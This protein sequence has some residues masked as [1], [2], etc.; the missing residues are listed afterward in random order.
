MNETR[1]S[2]ARIPLRWMIRECFKAKTGILFDTAF[3]YTIGLDPATLYGRDPERPELSD[4]LIDQARKCAIQER[5]STPS[6]HRFRSLFKKKQEPSEKKDV[7]KTPP[8]ISEDNEDLQDA[9][10]PMYDQMKINRLWWI[11]EILP[12]KMRYQCEKDN[13]KEKVDWHS[14][15]TLVLS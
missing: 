12:V 14:Y 8:F 4:S 7:L 11:L 15:T 2:L 5:K 3:L 9:L 10:S 6:S 13:D 1:H